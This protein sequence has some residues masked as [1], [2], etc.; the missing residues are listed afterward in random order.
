MT[1]FEKGLYE[2]FMKNMVTE[3]TLK[4]LVAASKL[5]KSLVD[6][7]VSERLEKWGY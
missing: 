1:D 4:K 2:Q 7:W 5:N 6:D 3:N